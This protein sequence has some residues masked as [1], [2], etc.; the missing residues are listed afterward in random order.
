M[1]SIDMCSMWLA[2][3]GASLSSWKGVFTEVV[4]LEEYRAATLPLLVTRD[5][6]EG[7]A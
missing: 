4:A 2:M 1:Y 7:I 3:V 5:T 6:V